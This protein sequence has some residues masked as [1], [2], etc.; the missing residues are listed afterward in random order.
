[1]QVTHGPATESGAGTTQGK[2]HATVLLSGM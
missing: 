1:V 2:I